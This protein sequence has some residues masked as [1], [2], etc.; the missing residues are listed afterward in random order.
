MTTVMTGATMSLDGYIAD[1]S[2]GGFEHLFQWYANGD[3]ETP[4]ADPTMT[5]R[6][7][8]ASARHLRELNERTGALVVGRRLF[9]I[10]KG[11]G[12]RHPMDVPVVVVTHHV[13]DGWERENESFVFVTDGIERAIA[14]AKA[15]AGDK[16]V[17]V[18]GGTIATQVIEAGLL[19]EV[20]VDLVPVL[21]GGGIPLF[22]DLGI[23][24]VLLDGPTRVVEGTGVTHLAY[25]VRSAG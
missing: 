9:D 15:I 21:L 11:W 14:R 5:F 20:H 13:P 3:V 1:A 10:T 19:D 25:R 8:A 22:A 4:T 2:H 16:H 12:G 18:N 6:T 7:S 24:P 17:G 23:A